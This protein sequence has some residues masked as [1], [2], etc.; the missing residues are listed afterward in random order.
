MNQLKDLRA[1][2]PPE[3]AL[4]LISELCSGLDFAHRKRDAQGRLLQLIHRDVSPHNV[5]ISAEGEVKIVDFGIAKSL[6]TPQVTEAGVIKG[7]FCF[8]SPEQA[9]GIKLDH[10]SDIFSAGILLYELLTGRPM[11]ESSDD[12]QLLQMVRGAHYIPCLL[13]TSPSPRD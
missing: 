10:R 9:Q 4:Y 8:M 2:I 11:Y 6:A 12:H 13:Y 7:K 5:M 1:F 3:A